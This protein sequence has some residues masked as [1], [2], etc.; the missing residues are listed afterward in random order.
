M[1]ETLRSMLRDTWTTTLQGLTQLLPKLV[2]GALIVVV[3]LLVGRLVR[4]LT[5]RFFIALRLDRVSDR[6]GLSAFLARGDAQYTVAEVVGTIIYWLVVMLSLQMMGLVL[7][8]QGL[9]DFFGQILTYLPRLV[10]ATVIVAVG[11]AIGSFFGSAV[12]VASANS[13]FP[14]SRAL[15]RT[16][17]YLIVFFAL[18]LA[19]EE[20][21]IASRLLATTFLVLI[22]AFALTLALAFGLGCRDLAREAVERWMRGKQDGT[23]GNAPRE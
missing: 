18:A 19:F 22:G 3:G 15:G 21:D 17:K 20:L 12:Q 7:G 13:G 4:A 11:T 23:P 9:A 1:G 14:V 2:V 8:L 6:L 16:V 10:V 5:V